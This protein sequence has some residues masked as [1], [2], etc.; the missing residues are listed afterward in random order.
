MK[1][2]PAPPDFCPS[3]ISAI[4]PPHSSRAVIVLGALLA[5]AL[6]AVAF[7]T[8]RQRGPIA[9]PA[10]HLLTYRRGTIRMVR[11]APDANI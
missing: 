6:A 3:G 9:T 5:V 8:L 10:Y 4:P 1:G 7:L 2:H 11:F